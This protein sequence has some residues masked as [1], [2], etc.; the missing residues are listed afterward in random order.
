[1]WAVTAAYGVGSVVAFVFAGAPAGSW[2]DAVLGPLILV[3]MI[4]GTVHAFVLRG[5]VFAPRPAEPAAAAA[6]AAA[7]REEDS[8]SAAGDVV[9]A[10][11]LRAG[12]PGLPR[13]AD[14]GGLVDVNQVPAQVLVDRLGLSPVQAS[15]VVEARVRLGGF[16]GPQELIAGS[17][18]P[19][20][21]VN[22]VRERLLFGASGRAAETRDDRPGRPSAGDGKGVPAGWYPDPAGSARRR[23]WDG[24]NWGRLTEPATS[25]FSRWAAAACLVPFV[26]ACAQ[27]ALLL[28]VIPDPNA[29]FP[30]ATEVMPGLGLLWLASFV[31]VVACGLLGMRRQ[32]RAAAA[33]GRA[34]TPPAPPHSTA[35]RP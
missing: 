15:Q 5:R 32:S 12:Q 17:G 2:R 1:M 33:G 14:A 9:L 13:Q 3:L 31:M 6:P 21:T 4:V 10:G 30:S 18:L 35:S 34:D 8:A 29:A 20:A 22:A 26:A 25:I 7:K 28:K 11:E 19:E 27:P 16:A 23:F 24:T